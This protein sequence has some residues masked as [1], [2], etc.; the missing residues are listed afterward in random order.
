[1]KLVILG[2]TGLV[3]R[4]MLLEALDDPA[5]SHVLSVGRTEVAELHP[6]LRQLVH[7]DLYNATPIQNELRGHD[8]CAYCVGVSAIGMTEIEYTRITY[9]MTIAFANVFLAANPNSTFLY[10]TGQ[11]TDSSEKGSMMWA[12]VKGRTENALLAMPFKSATMFRPGVIQPHRGIKSRT[13]MYNMG[14][15]LVRPLA[16]WMVRNGK[17]TSTTLMGQAMLEVIERPPVQRL[18]G[19]KEINALGQQRIDRRR[20]AT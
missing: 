19:N 9:D 18:L 4:G 20:A 11:G 10:V 5:V 2:S 13:A 3:G 14:F 7:A 8:A 12:R 16:S 1:M 17:A 6:K 15:A